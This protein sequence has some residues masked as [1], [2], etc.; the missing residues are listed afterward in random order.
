MRATTLVPLAALVLFAFFRAL[1]L[2]PIGDEFWAFGGVFHLLRWLVGISHE[3]LSDYLTRAWAYAHGES[4]N[5][6]IYHWY[7]VKFAW[8]LVYPLLAAW[9]SLL[10]EAG[11]WWLG[12]S[13]D[14]LRLFVVAGN[15][16]LLFHWA[17]VVA[18]TAW[19][20]TRIRDALLRTEL[21]SVALAVLL[22]DYAV[23]ANYG[24]LF[25]GH[26]LFGYLHE[27]FLYALTLWSP[28][29]VVSLI[30]GLF[31]A[32]R[33]LLPA[34]RPLA[35]IPLAFLFHVPS[36]TITCVLLG[37]A[38]A[39]WCVG[40]RRATREFVM[41]V[42]CGL[43][44]LGLSATVGF[45]GH[46][47]ADRGVLPAVS[48]F[49]MVAQALWPPTPKALMLLVGI[50]V[51]TG[52]SLRAASTQQESAALALGAGAASAGLL[53]VQVAT[54]YAVA[55]GQLTW[56]D[57]P[58]VHSL[59]YVFSYSSSTVLLGVTG[60]GCVRAGRWLA[61]VTGQR[62][63]R[64][65]A[66]ACVA[67]PLLALVFVLGLLT[68]GRPV[69][70]L[71]LRPPGNLTELLRQ[72]RDPQRWQARYQAFGLPGESLPVL[73][74]DDRRLLLRKN[75]MFNSLVYLRAIHQSVV[76]GEAASAP[77]VVDSEGPDAGQGALWPGQIQQQPPKKQRGF[78]EGRQF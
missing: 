49:G 67:S 43:A 31:L 22:F 5:P 50:V 48:V 69:E 60:W 53:L 3:P 11:R 8:G 37:A 16:A 40:H 45:T 51:L 30:L 27:G 14:Y 7:H 71:G 44:G 39:L 1:G 38:E 41:L 73:P 29:S 55:A 34:R 25:H 19:A 35:L 63:A 42:A 4:T 26:R 57:N 10:A 58:S 61:L 62:V 36:A 75:Y 12:R 2:S 70:A 66:P 15:L 59:L 74:F 33:L 24:A 72:I 56:H 28:R 9:Y 46:P 68:A 13:V 54:G 20:F 78:S 64:A 18:A 47:G 6:H 21:A 23:Q 65:L 52:L 77:I 32:L 76:L 17:S